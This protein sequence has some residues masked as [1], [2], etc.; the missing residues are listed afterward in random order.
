MSKNIERR[1]FDQVYGKTPGWTVRPHES[2]DF[3][4]RRSDIVILGVEVT[5]YFHSES[6]ARLQRIPGYAKE[7]LGVRRYRHSNDKNSLRVEKITYL[8]GAIRP[9]AS[10]SMRLYAKCRS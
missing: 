5:E 10:N 1:I 8:P 7:L 6:D 4:C 3:L 9:K 2:P